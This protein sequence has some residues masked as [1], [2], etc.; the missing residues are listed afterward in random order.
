MIRLTLLSLLLAGLIVYSWK[1]WYKS[2]C[3]LVLLMAVVEH[4]DMPKS[5][6]GIQGL[7]PWNICFAFIVLAWLLNRRKEGLT[8]DM[9]RHIN[10]LLLLYLGVILV[11][12]FRLLYGGGGGLASIYVGGT[13][14]GMGTASAVSEYLINSIKW[15]VPGLAIYD[16]CR[17]RKRLY[18]ALACVLGLYFLLGV[19]VIKWMPM[20]EAGSG[21][22]LSNRSLKIL[23]N[24][25]GYHRVNMSMM[26][27]GAAW[28]VLAT[29]ILVKNAVGS[30]LIVLA[31]LTIVFA[32][33][34]TGGRTGYA[35]WAL[36]G[37]ILCVVRWRK[38]LLL[39][40]VFAVIVMIAVPGAVGRMMQ[41]FTAE[42]RD[43]NAYL[44]RQG[45]TYG[46]EGPDLYTVTAGRNIAWHYVVPKIEESPWLGYGRMAMQTTGIMM[47]IWDKTREVFPH[48]HN[49]YLELLLDNGLLGFV[50]VISFFLVVLRRSFALFRSSESP[51]YSAVGGVSLALV[52]A[53]LI[54][55]I[56]SQ[57]FYPREGSV[58]MW[59][60]IGMMLRVWTDR[61]RTIR[62]GSDSE[63]GA[64]VIGNPWTVQA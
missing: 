47:T 16:G 37:A 38:L 8:W 62:G 12:F 34:L 54:A 20:S 30:V 11:G 49:A 40:P 19:Q 14:F 46:G 23:V 45:I 27:A 13:S 36:V 60:G 7:N 17:D 2:L 56:G 31:S 22:A 21:S 3:G 39:A 35:T 61:Q 63:E 33:A 4:P 42:T 15:V 26:L 52:L 64:P 24:E 50:I 48:P 9:P 55:S 43:S 53:L 10:V 6:M 59:C 25:I 57:S 29:R 32:Q 18:I 41:G 58:G 44:D 51:I 1:D 5:I 28:A